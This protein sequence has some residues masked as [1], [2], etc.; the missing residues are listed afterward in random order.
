MKLEYVLFVYPITHHAY[1]EFYSCYFSSF[2]EGGWHEEC[3]IWGPA[4]CVDDSSIP[5]YDSILNGK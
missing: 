1:N 2:T 4:S 5:E 3:K